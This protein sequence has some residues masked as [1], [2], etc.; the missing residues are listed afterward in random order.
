MIIF[1]ESHLFSLDGDEVLAIAASING[2]LPTVGNA[3]SL[4]L[5]ELGGKI[6]ECE[7]LVGDLLDEGKTTA[8]E[9]EAGRPTS[10]AEV[11]CLRGIIEKVKTL[12]EIDCT[13]LLGLLNG[14]MSGMNQQS[15]LAKQWN[16]GRLAATAIDR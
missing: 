7:D 10:E 1:E 4:L 5:T 13:Y 16:D 9:A 2:S 11:E 6:T 3:R 14:F 12:S 8:E 15:P